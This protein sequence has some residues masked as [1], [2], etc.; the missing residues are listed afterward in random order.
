LLDIGIAANQFCLRAA[1]LGLGTCMI[2]WFNEKEVKKLLH[3][4]S[5]RRVPLLISV[6]Y[7]AGATREKVRK[8]VEE[9]SRWNTY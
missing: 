2:G 9:M 7:P 3:I 6:G 8:P 5:G 1:D 4:P